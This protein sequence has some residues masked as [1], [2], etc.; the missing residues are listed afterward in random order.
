M[1]ITPDENI[2]SKSSVSVYKNPVHQGGTLH[3]RRIRNCQRSSLNNIF[4]SGQQEIGSTYE[5][6]TSQLVQPDVL[7][8]VTGRPFSKQTG[9]NDDN[10]ERKPRTRYKQFLFGTEI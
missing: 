7:D 2:P 1:E 6:G 9:R 3:G 5:S 10:E 4:A 8:I